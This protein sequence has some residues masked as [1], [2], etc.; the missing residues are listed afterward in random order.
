MTPRS[1]LEHDIDRQ[2]DARLRQW[3]IDS[4]SL[5]EMAG[6]PIR[7]ALINVAVLLMTATGRLTAETGA[8]PEEVGNA[9]RIAVKN[10]RKD[11]KKAQATKRAP[12]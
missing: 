2:V 9:M 10:Y 7:T 5:Y 12:P 8:S 6:L 3:F 11:R 1:V 4:M